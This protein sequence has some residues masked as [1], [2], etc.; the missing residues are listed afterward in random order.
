MSVVVQIQWNAI[1]SF[2]RQAPSM[3]RLISI[4]DVLNSRTVSQLEMI[5]TRVELVLYL[6]SH[7]QA[8]KALTMLSTFIP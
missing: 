3:V 1:R 7:R 6:V 4:V 8:V 5:Y 2:I